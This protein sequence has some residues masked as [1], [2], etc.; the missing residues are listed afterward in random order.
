MQEKTD[1]F[2]L[3]GNKNLCFSS[4]FYTFLT[5]DTFNQ[6]VVNW[7]LCKAYLVLITLHVV[8]TDEMIAKIIDKKSAKRMNKIHK[9]YRSLNISLSWV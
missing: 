4:F 5:L 2:S 6:F 7:Y 9:Y 8:R 1:G 3:F